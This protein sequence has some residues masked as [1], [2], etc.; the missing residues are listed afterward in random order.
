MRKHKFTPK[1]IA[2]AMSDE[3]PERDLTDEILEYLKAAMAST[4][5]EKAKKYVRTAYMYIQSPGV[6]VMASAYRI[7]TPDESEYPED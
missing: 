7:E 4:T 2:E 1:T 3:K 6:T 5:L